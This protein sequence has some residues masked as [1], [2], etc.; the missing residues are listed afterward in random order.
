[1]RPSAD[2]N[3]NKATAINPSS[4]QF[5]TMVMKHHPYFS[6]GAKPAVN[7]EQRVLV[8]QVSGKELLFYGLL[9]FLLAFAILRRLFPKYFNDLFRL[10]FRTTLKH[11]QVREQ[12]MQ[13]PLPSLLLNGFFIISGAFYIS[14]LVQHYKADPTGNFWI[15]FAYAGVG[16][17]VIYFLKFIGLKVSGWVFGVQEAANSYVFIVFII[18]KMIGI[19]LIPFLF[20][21]A[22]SVDMVYTAG[23]VL[24]WF[25][26][27]GLLGY[28]LILTWGAVRNQVKLN[29]FHFFLYLLA[30]EVAPLLLV[31]KAL[32][33]FFSQTA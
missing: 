24:S 20:I 10:F 31:Y 30:F 23:L 6:F 22:F 17:S 7:A 5:S 16:L 28:R 32:L 12:L 27:G 21:L 25:L 2:S 33:L 15:L 29:L 13:T 26:V 19:M 11:K 1:M 4:P 18:N 14:F 8:R 9:V 3:W